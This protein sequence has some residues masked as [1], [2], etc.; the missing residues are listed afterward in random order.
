MKLYLHNSSQDTVLESAFNLNCY[1]FEYS[2]IKRII[3]IVF[4]VSPFQSRMRGHIGVELKY[5]ASPF[6]EM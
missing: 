3:T 5:F 1:A 6:D 4:L 2:E